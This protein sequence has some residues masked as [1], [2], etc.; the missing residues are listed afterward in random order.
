MTDHQHEVDVLS[1]SLAQF[2][3]LIEGLS[4]DD[5]ARPTPCADWSVEQLSNHVVG[6]TR[7][8]AAT[9]Q[10]RDVDWAAPPEPIDDRARAFQGAVED[11]LTGW[12]AVDRSADGPGPG[13]QIAEIATHTWDLGTAL[14]KPIDRLDPEV[15]ERGLAFMQANLSADMRGSAFASEQVVPESAD[16]YTRL[17]A[18]AGRTL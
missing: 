10:G 9:M 6:S 2:G 17:A 18:F 1:S 14:G 13:M 15:A 12:R 16:A 11:L 7:N 5:L 4:R 3:V 8:F